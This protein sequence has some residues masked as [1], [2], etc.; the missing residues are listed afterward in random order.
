VT[1]DSS[2]GRHNRRLPKSEASRPFWLGR[3]DSEEAKPIQEKKKAKG[4]S[5]A[6]RR[7]G[8]QKN[9]ETEL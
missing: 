8:F 3:S 7:L 6:M 9:R 5:A 1:P 2:G 4:H